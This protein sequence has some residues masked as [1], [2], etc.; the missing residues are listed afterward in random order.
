MGASDNRVSYYSPLAELVRS[1]RRK[2]FL[3]IIVDEAGLALAVAFGA[4]I[5]LLVLGT[6]LLDWY[7]VGAIFA[8]GACVGF[9]RGRQR[10]ASGYEIA[11]K[12]DQNLALKDALSTALYFEENPARIKSPAT[13]VERQRELAQDLARSADIHRG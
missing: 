6:Q 10:I 1:A 9:W 12:L 7:W 2:H 5:V 4:A 11:R 13:V 3:Q 8:A